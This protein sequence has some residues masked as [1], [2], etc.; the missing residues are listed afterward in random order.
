[1]LISPTT[2]NVQFFCRFISAHSDK[3]ASIAHWDASID[4][5]PKAPEDIDHSRGFAVLAN[6]ESPVN[7]P[8]LVLDTARRTGYDI[9]M[10][11]ELAS[12]VPISN[13]DYEN[14]S[15]L[16]LPALLFEKKQK[17]A[18]IVTSNCGGANF[19]LSAV[20]AMQDM[21]IQVDSYGQCMHN[22]DF[23]GGSLSARSC[24]V[25]QTFWMDFWVLHDLKKFQ[26]LVPNGIHLG[27]QFGS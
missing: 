3:A 27:Q 9:T 25:R 8:G 23:A 5:D 13:L 2:S 12:D 19:R 10:T 18:I 6:G 20:Q 1:M 15:N 17:A 14:V 26:G 24:C 21:G 11:I 22:K 7:L 4:P 16:F